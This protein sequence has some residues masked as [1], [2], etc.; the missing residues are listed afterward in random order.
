[1]LLTLLGEIRY[2]SE[3]LDKG[4]ESNHLAVLNKQYAQQCCVM[5]AKSS[6]KQCCCWSPTSTQREEC[7]I[8]KMDAN[9]FTHLQ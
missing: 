4:S 6:A 2:G 9:E 5:P 8:K 3:S 7:L 1:M